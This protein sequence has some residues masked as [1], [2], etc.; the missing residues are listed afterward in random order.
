LSKKMSSPRLST[1]AAER[2]E[3]TVEGEVTVEGEATGSSG[4]SD[5]LLR[6]LSSLRVVLEVVKPLPITRGCSCV[7]G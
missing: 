3:A 5:L 7:F 6:L 2:R 4:I 1:L